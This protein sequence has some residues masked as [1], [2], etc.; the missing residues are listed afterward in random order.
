M[1]DFKVGEGRK[2]GLGD[3]EPAIFGTVVNNGN[4]TLKEVEITVYFLDW[5]G[6]VIGETNFYPVLVTE[7][8]FGSSNKPLKLNYVKDFGYSVKDYAP[9]GWAKKVK[10][11]ITNIEFAD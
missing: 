7:F 10:V 1:R 11:K 3:P 9:S 2:Y 5:N 6:I 4:R 8:S